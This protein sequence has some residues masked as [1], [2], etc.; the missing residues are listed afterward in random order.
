MRVTYTKKVQLYDNATG[1]WAEFDWS[2]SEKVWRCRDG[3]ASEGFFST[4]PDI[5]RTMTEHQ[6]LLM[7]VK[8]SEK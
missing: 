2:N 7:S 3:H 6:M 1:Y 5:P 8:N 4:F